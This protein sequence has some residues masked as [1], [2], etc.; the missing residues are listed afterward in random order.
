MRDPIRADQYAQTKRNRLNAGF[1]MPVERVRGRALQALRSR[2]LRAK[3]LCVMCDAQGRV[4][5][6]TELDHVVAL[7]NGG[8]NDESNLQGLCAE[9]HDI[10]TRTDLGQRVGGC[11]ASGT[12]IDPSHHWNKPG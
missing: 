10:K 11:D 4:R 1:F 12:P 2:L 9:C 5:A 3:P 6:A 7:V 8:T